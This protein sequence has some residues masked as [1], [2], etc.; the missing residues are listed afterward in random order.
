MVGLHGLVFEPQ[1]GE[2]VV[3]VHAP[4]VALVSRERRE[5]QGLLGRKPKGDAVISRG[6]AK[7]II[8]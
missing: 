3:V 6:V 8:Y 4:A 2:V 7:Y 5:R 1:D